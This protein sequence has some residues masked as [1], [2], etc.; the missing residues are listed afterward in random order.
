MRTENPA[1]P[2]S[3]LSRLRAPIA[4]ARG[5][6][7]DRG[8]FARWGLPAAALAA[9]AVAVYLVTPVESTGSAWLY[10][11]A[12]LPRDEALRI[13]QVLRA[14][15]VDSTT[16]K[17]GR[18]AVP[19]DKLGEAMALLE[20]N[21][22]GPRSPGYYIDRGLESHPWDGPREQELRLGRAREQA[23]EA[24]FEKLDGI[25]SAYVTITRARSR[26]LATPGVV[27][28]M[29]L[30]DI[31]GERTL[32]FATIKAIQN[33][34]VGSEPDL[35]PDAVT[36]GDSRGTTYLLAGNPDL[37]AESQLRAR[38]E[39][40]TGELREQLRW[41]DGVQVAVKLEPPPAPPK[42]A[43]APV[44]VP[45]AP[46]D[47]SP[48]P[49]AEPIPA[50]AFGKARVFIQVPNGHYLHEF[51]TRRP[52]REPS[53]EDLAPFVAQVDNSI[54]NAV[55]FVVPGAEVTIDRISTAD[56]AV[57]AA[58]PSHAEGHRISTEWAI[59]AAV[60][61]FATL[62]LVAMLRIATRRPAERSSRW[63]DHGRFD[64]GE[65]AGPGPSERVRDLVRRSP[66]AA[67]GVLQRWIGQGEHAG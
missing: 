15:K 10:D 48:E 42:P 33:M 51:R 18:I 44:A 25:A 57:P 49:A 36:I 38:E 7:G 54:H 14:G 13:G 11:G 52:N 21:K 4:R 53:P 2:G 23:F 55:A 12:K 66:E 45:N 61:A 60:A 40:L 67:A 19:A 47:L 9:L 64:R 22:L 32:P 8:A 34:L 43:N 59:T 20:K 39:E 35:K 26:S 31:E 5:W 1:P 50:V 16:D 17:Q 37:G 63:S 56:A 29:V 3:T 30:L 6:L 24:L 65:P 28:A 58:L 62:L 41:I 27:K 46:M